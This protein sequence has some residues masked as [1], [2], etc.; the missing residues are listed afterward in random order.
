MVHHKKTIYSEEYR[1]IIDKLTQLRKQQGRTQKDVA[2]L[3]GV[4]QSYISKIENYQIRMDILQLKQFADI[5]QVK[6]DDLLF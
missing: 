6:L 4:S 1:S 5:Y 3:T 2:N